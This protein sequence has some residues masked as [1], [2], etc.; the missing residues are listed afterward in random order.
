MRDEGTVLFATRRYRYLQESMLKL[1]QLIEGTVQVQDF[2]DGERY[3]RLLTAVRGRSAIVIG[4]TVSD[5]ATLELYDLASAV[6]EY[7]ANDLTIVVPYFG[8]STMERAKRPGEVITA[9]IRARLLSSVPAAPLG[10][11]VVLVDLHT[12]GIPHYFEGAVRVTHLY[13]KPIVMDAIRELG[14]DG[15]VLAAAD[16]G[17]AKWVQ[18]LGNDLG[19]ETAYVMKRRLSAEKTEIEAISAHVRERTVVLYDDMVRTGGSLISAAKAY[20]DAGASAISV[21]CTHGLFCGD[22]LHRLRESG[23]FRRI[24]CT[25]SH[26]RSLELEDTFLTVRSIAPLLIGHLRDEY[27][28]G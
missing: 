22:A 5:A 20:R 9:K 21:V 26:P 3:Q 25:D 7:G 27:A 2:P 28:I 18:S 24:I 12:E 8:Y 6:S 10:N 23:L 4:G 11:K 13:A 16:A 15:Y 1:G 19:V 14:G 17:R